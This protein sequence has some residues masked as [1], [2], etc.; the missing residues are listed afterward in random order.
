MKF[1]GIVIVILAVLEGAGYWAYKVSQKPKA[2]SEENIQVAES[3]PQLMS[4][5]AESAKQEAEEAQ[6][7]NVLGSFEIIDLDDPANQE[8]YK[9]LLNLEII[10]YPLIQL[11][12]VDGQTERNIHIGVRQWAWD[13]AELDAKKGEKVRLIVH[14]NADYVHTIEIPDFGVK[15][16]IP[17]EGAVV[18]FMADK[19]GT[20]EYFCDG[21]DHEKM[22]AKIR[23]D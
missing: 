12:E 1:I 20:F 9:D 4:N 5:G 22:V 16:D 19:S 15:V 23:I 3:Q 18:E 2:S 13:P 10:T 14:N 6:E 8:K 11:E 17:G 7:E 21:A